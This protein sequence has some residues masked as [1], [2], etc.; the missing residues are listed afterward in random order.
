MAFD[1]FAAFMSDIRNSTSQLSAVDIDVSAYVDKLEL[2]G[3]VKTQQPELEE[4]CSEISAL[5]D[6]I[7]EVGIPVPAFEAAELATLDGDFDAMK[8]AIE[9]VCSCYVESHF[10]AYARGGSASFCARVF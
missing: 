4:R 6:L 2:L 3:V 9:E 5:Y 7:H 8:N 1:I 10:F